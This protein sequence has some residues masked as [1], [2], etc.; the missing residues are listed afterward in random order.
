M[1]LSLILGN[2]A[3]TEVSSSTSCATPI[4]VS[5]SHAGHAT[6]AA[7]AQ[8]ATPR[9]SFFLAPWDAETG[10]AQATTEHHKQDGASRKYTRNDAKF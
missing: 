7:D 4:E 10:H 8:H 6:Y 9:A 1:N 3:Q 5:R 2:S